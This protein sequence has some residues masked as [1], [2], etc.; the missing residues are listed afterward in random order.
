MKEEHYKQLL[1]VKDQQIKTLENRISNIGL[2]L[3]NIIEGRL[4]EKGNLLVYELDSANRILNLFKNAMFG[5][6]QNLIRKI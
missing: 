6:E 5:L 3:E 2:N 1:F 4:F